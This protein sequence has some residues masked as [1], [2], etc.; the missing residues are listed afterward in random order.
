VSIGPDV[1]RARTAALGSQT[2]RLANAKPGPDLRAG[3]K[4]EVKGALSTAGTDNAITVMSLQ[5]VAPVC[6]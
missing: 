6:E 1:D 2:I 4:V 3:A 5:M